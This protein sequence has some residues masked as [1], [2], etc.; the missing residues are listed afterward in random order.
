[1]RVG[2]KMKE[3]RYRKHIRYFRN[4][5]YA[6]IILLV[7]VLVPLSVI[8]FIAEEL[9]LAI[10]CL[11]ICG[12]LVLEELLFIKMYNRFLK[13]KVSLTED[14]IVYTNAKGVTTI[15]YEAI[16]QIQFPS[17]KYL[18]GW[19]KIIS[20]KDV[21]R[22]T[23]VIEDIA[24]FLLEFKE[25]LDAHELGHLYTDKH[26][27]DF[28]KTST[29]ADMSWAR[30]Y[31]IFLKFIL[32]TILSMV[33]SSVVGVIVAI[34][35]ARLNFWLFGFIYPTAV[36]TI[37]E[38]ILGQMMRKKFKFETYQVIKN[39]LEAEN[40]VYKW[41][42]IIGTVVYFILLVLFIAPTFI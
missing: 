12:L 33:I 20:G 17:L 2:E 41:T 3:Y 18:G 9:G 4:F 19:I 42:L 14:A 30:M 28:F 36:Y 26:Y 11:I 8:F 34:G 24:E 15:P 38:L 39:D 25:Q 5:M 37:S 21:I 31:R 22:L 40:T 23:V 10:A 27:R 29:Y 16:D 35:D 32:L 1:M 7:L 13:V 6:T